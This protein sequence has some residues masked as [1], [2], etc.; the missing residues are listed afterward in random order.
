[1]MATPPADSAFVFVRS[2]LSPRPMLMVP[3]ITVTCSIAGC[4]CA[5]IW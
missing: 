3:E 4:E 1:M 5:G 2:S